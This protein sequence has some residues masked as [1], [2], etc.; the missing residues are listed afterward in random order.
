MDYAT[1]TSLHATSLC[2][3]CGWKKSCENG[4]KG[5]S[6][7][8]NCEM[9]T[10]DVRKDVTKDDVATHQPSEKLNWEIMDAYLDCDFD[11]STSECW[12]FICQNGL[13]IDQDFHDQKCW[14][15]E[16]KGMQHIFQTRFL[17]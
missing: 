15:K 3:T 7:N 4:C 16:C 10:K 11:A 6:I 2:T 17:K 13:P 8:T 12:C 14:C 1:S 5:I 9:I